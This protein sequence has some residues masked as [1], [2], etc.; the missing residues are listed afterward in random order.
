VLPDGTRVD[1]A[2]SSAGRDLC[3]LPV[4]YCDEDAFPQSMSGL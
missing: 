4:S 2:R 1:L 3:R